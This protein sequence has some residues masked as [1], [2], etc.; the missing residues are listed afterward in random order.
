MHSRT[1]LNH[2]GK[3]PAPAVTEG[4]ITGK[5]ELSAVQAQAGA[6]ELPVPLERRATV[7]SVLFPH[8]F[9][10]VFPPRLLS[11]FAKDKLADQRPSADSILGRLRRGFREMHGNPLAHPWCR[12]RELLRRIVPPPPNTRTKQTG[13]HRHVKYESCHGSFRA[14]KVLR[15][16]CPVRTLSRT[17]NDVRRRSPMSYGGKEGQSGSG[18]KPA[19]PVEMD[20]F[21]LLELPRFQICRL[22]LPCRRRP[23]RGHIFH[24]GER[25]K[26]P[27]AKTK[28][29]DKPFD[30][31]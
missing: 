23:Q 9:G 10:N 18:R 7:Y 27:E 2:R 20:M 1:H 29:L 28:A 13:S 8:S 17:F 12:R 25:R 21:A 14:F 11:A 5:P 4:P 15:C 3:V 31:V 16:Q 22:V 19:V 30:K 6:E 26:T 24:D